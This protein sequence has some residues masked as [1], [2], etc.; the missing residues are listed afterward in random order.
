MITRRNTLAMLA[1]AAGSSFAGRRAS[2][3]PALSLTDLRG[4]LDAGAAGLSPG[5]EDQTGKLLA[6]IREAVRTNQW[7]F[8]PAGRYEVGRLS[9]PDKTRL[10]GIAGATEI[11]F[12][13]GGSFLGSEGAG[14]IEL[15]NITFDGAG[16]PLSENAP[17]MLHLRDVDELSINNCVVTGCRKTGLQLERC[18]GTV[19]DCQISGIGEYGIYALDSRGLSVRENRLADCGN[20]GILIHR[21]EV[22]EDGSIVSGNRIT[23]TGATYGGTGQFG[24]AINLYRA[25]GVIVSSNHISDSA[26]TAIRANASSNIQI[27]DNQCLRSGETAIYSEFG[28]EGAMVTSN[29]I[30]GAANGINI[31]NFN[32]GGRLAIVSNNI[33]RNISLTGPYE[34]DSVGFGIGIGVEADTVVSGNLLENVPRFGMLLGWGPYL[35]NVAATGNI[36]RSA[37][38]GCAVSVVE[39]AGSALISDNIFEGC[40]DGAIRG[41]RWHETATAELAAGGATFEH[42]TIG[43][44]RIG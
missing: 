9:L 7:V 43:G 39:E 41:F 20:G 5:R 14:R 28:F 15:S 29:L 44:N 32:E 13:G 40:G 18:G 2:A 30:D 6:L 11:A 16:L 3:N 21:S 33:V 1:L 22:G 25:G 19:R 10:V 35:R 42:L 37:R 36:V 34:H 38:I 8:L 26:F 17:A 31:A 24:N 27:S 4:S 12:A 23:R